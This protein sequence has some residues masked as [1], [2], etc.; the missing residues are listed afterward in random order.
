[1]LRT[2][3]L[4]LFYYLKNYHKVYNLNNLNR[5]IINI[6]NNK[7][8]IIHNKNSYNLIFNNQRLYHK[9][10]MNTS[11]AKS[12][13]ELVN[14]IKKERQ[15]Q[16]DGIELIAS[17]NYTSASVMQC[18]G[19]VLTNKYSEG[20]PGR[21]YYGGNQW[22]DEIEWLCKSRAL[23]CYNLDKEKW[24]VNVQPYSG[25]PANFGVY[26]AIL[27]P[28]DRIMG[29]DLPS[30]GHLT[31]GF[32]TAKKKVSAT[33]LYF[34]SLP[35]HIG[36][37]DLIDFDDLEKTALRFKPKL[38]IC[39]ASAYPR[40]ID[41]P[42]FREI[43]DKVG[44]YLMCDM[45]HI[46]GLVATGALNSPFQYCDVVT[47]TTHKT[48]RGPRSGMVFIRK[49]KEGHTDWP[50]LLDDAIFP[51]LQGGP[52]NHQIAGVAHQL[53]MAQ[54]PDFKEYINNVVNNA[55]C[56][57]RELQ[58]LGFDISS[59]GTDN[60]IV[61]VKLRN[62]GVSGSKMEK[63]CELVDISLN[64]NSVYGDKNPMNPTGI[65]LGTSP[66]TTRGFGPE[67]F[68][69]VAKFLRDCVD[70]CLVLQEKYGKKLVDFNKGLSQELNDNNSII[71]KNIENIKNNVQMLAR[72]F[73][74]YEG[75]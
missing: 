7:N 69:Q 66:M 21:R 11:L 16:F 33:S 60:H 45:A 32:Y 46:S 55:R 2:F 61:L 40:E 34:E 75:M 20:Q 56:L 74:F 19:D 48:L 5:T 3:P 64:K 63:I 53:M 38:I 28:H 71:K 22:I 52:H 42:R 36:P 18:L 27:N 25:S 57:A 9:S 41:Y 10:S 44:A 17:E 67:E 26:T 73:E 14:L 12:D 4:Q 13:P 29:L 59:G 6:I 65:R 30:G 23:Q 8:N 15:R 31:H 54:K 1:M 49:D 51:G 35:Y 47:T 68:K 58:E 43:A 37:D 62:T 39:G 70:V 50:T 72:S 24:H